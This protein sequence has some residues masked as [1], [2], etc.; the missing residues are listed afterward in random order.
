MITKEFIIQLNEDTKKRY[1]LQEIQRAQHSQKVCA[2]LML[3][4]GKKEKSSWEIVSSSTPNSKF[5]EKYKLKLSL[6]QPLS[7]T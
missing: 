4:I 7:L 1:G 6:H 5:L 3:K 2:K